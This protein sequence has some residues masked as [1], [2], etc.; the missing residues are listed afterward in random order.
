VL[1]GLSLGSLFERFGSRRVLFGVLGGLPVALAAY[2]AAPNLA[3]GVVTI[4]VVGFLY[5]GALSSFVTIAQLRAPAE[6]RGRVM[7]LLMVLL[8]ALYP[9]GSVVQGAVADRVGLRVTTAGA[10]ALMA[11]ALLGARLLR[12]QVARA[13][14]E[15]VELSAAE[16]ST[17]DGDEPDRTGHLP[18]P[19][20]AEAV[21]SGDGARD[22]ERNQE[23]GRAH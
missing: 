18:E 4:F 14:D 20:C 9:L 5:L 11:A 19:P 7:S 22:N 10:G 1:M 6:L 21:V 15:R 12:P 8:G 3:V 17:R 13:L 23:H 2:A 16:G